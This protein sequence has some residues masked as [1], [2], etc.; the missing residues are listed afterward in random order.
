[1]GSSKNLREQAQEENLKNKMQEI[2]RPRINK[3]NLFFD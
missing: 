2:E 3:K 1:M